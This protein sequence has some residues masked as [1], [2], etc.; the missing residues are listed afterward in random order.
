MTVAVAAILAR[1]DK[2]V[3]D[4]A[5]L[6]PVAVALANSFVA[7]GETPVMGFAGAVHAPSQSNGTSAIPVARNLID[8]Y[9]YLLLE[10]VRIVRGG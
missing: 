10:Y 6:A 1:V 3:A 8:G 7:E 2:A 4:G 5:G 9:T